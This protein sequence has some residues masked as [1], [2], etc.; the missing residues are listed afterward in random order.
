M[1]D[2]GNRVN[3]KHNLVQELSPGA[4]KN[5]IGKAIDW[6]LERCY[7]LGITHDPSKC[8]N[9]PDNQSKHACP[10][11]RETFSLK[12]CASQIAE[13]SGWQIM[14][15]PFDIYYTKLDSE[16]SEHLIHKAVFIQ[17]SIRAMD[18]KGLSKKNLNKAR[19]LASRLVEK[20]ARTHAYVHLAQETPLP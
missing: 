20:A 16:Q 5:E 10:I 4:E 15:A 12:F 18:Q 8:W 17:D 6:I 1:S 3:Y 2:L 9:P 7:E 11:W 14:A 13:C 19:K